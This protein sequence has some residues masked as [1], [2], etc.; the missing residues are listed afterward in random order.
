LNTLSGANVSFALL[1]R[2]QPTN[3]CALSDIRS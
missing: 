1:I 2:G 3:R